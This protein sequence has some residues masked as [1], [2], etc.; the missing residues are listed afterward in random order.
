[1]G[2]LLLRKLQETIM[3]TGDAA[4]RL[5]RDRRLTIITSCCYRTGL[6]SCQL[7]TENIVVALY[8]KGNSQHRSVHRLIFVR[9]L[10]LIARRRRVHKPTNARERFNSSETIRNCSLDAVDENSIH[11]VPL[12]RRFSHVVLFH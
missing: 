5:I 12:C 6:N 8:L 2:D 7:L 10:T 9:R 1:M 3:K 4:R 11:N